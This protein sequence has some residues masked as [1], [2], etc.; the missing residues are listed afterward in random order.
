MMFIRNEKDFINLESSYMAINIT[1]TNSR[2]HQVHE[3][4]EHG[5]MGM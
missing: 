4:K 3:Y 2:S 5:L 1:S